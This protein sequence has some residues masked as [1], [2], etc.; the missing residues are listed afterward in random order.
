[1]CTD[2]VKTLFNGRYNNWDDM[3]DGMC[4]VT[5]NDIS[6]FRCTTRRWALIETILW[7]VATIATFSPVLFTGEYEGYY[8]VLMVSNHQM[9]V[10]MDGAACKRQTNLNPPF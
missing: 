10:W 6:L 1:M 5:M 3:P 7:M 2:A 8:W 4:Q 9:R